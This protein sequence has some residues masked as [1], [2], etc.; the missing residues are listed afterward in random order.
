MANQVTKADLENLFKAI[1]KDNSGSISVDELYKA[2]G[3]QNFR[4]DEVE[5]LA[6][7]LDKNGDG[8]IN[9]DG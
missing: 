8:K 7:S 1:D 9:C 3:S 2:L 6:K 5:L 4:R